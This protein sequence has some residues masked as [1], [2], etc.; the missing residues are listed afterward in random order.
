[1]VTVACC[2]NTINMTQFSGN[3]AIVITAKH[4]CIRFVSLIYFRHQRDVVKFTRGLWW[5]KQSF[6][7]FLYVFDETLKHFSG[8]FLATLSQCPWTHQQCKAGKILSHF[9]HICAHIWKYL[10]TSRKVERLWSKIKY[11]VSH[12]NHKISNQL[13]RNSGWI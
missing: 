11:K 12:T 9:H 8:I 3:A 10:E 6:F 2:D 1:M 7:V 4:G 5:D 13:W